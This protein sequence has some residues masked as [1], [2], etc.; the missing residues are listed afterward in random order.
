VRLRVG[1]RGFAGCGLRIVCSRCYQFG[2]TIE[3]NLISN[4]LSLKEK[5]QYFTKR[6]IIKE[7]EQ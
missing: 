1:L 6:A 5:E 7:K 3:D 2:V 4:L